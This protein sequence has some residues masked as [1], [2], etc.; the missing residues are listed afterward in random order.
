MNKRADATF[1]YESNS[2]SEPNLDN[3]EGLR[4]DEMIE[5]GNEANKELLNLQVQLVKNPHMQP[6]EFELMR[7]VEK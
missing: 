4:K 2:D 5:V 3:P 1:V 7:A 6:T